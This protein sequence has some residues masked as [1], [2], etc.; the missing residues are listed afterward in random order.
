MH[1]HAKFDTD[2]HGSAT[3]VLNVSWSILLK[4]ESVEMVFSQIMGFTFKHF[5]QNKTV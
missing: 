4:A 1:V 2:I 5:I 3:T